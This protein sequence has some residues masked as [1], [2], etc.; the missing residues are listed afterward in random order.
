MQNL[1][2]RFDPNAML[3][4]GEKKGDKISLG[5]LEK[6]KDF[7]L[8]LSFLDKRDKAEELLTEEF[9]MIINDLEDNSMLGKVVAFLIRVPY[10]REMLELNHDGILPSFNETDG[11]INSKLDDE[12]L[13][14]EIENG[15]SKIFNKGQV[16]I[17]LHQVIL[18]ILEE[19][20]TAHNQKNT[21]GSL[22]TRFIDSITNDIALNQLLPPGN[23]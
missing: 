13:A 10:F 4:A 7:G 22:Y 15:L 8:D 20:I 18:D 19:A 21:G 9:F 16:N 12:R 6:L 2:P 11:Y 23:I 17:L 3:H 5:S 1:G 14:E